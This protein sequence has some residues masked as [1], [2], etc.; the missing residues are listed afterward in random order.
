MLVIVLNYSFA[1]TYNTDLVDYVIKNK[2]ISNLFNIGI[3]IVA[4]YYLFNR[5]FYLPFL[6]P[7]VIPIIQSSQEIKKEDLINV[8]LSNLPPNTNVI[9]WASLKSEKD[10]E[11]PIVAYQDYSNSGIE[12]TDATGNVNIKVVCPSPY[13]VPKFGIKKQLLQRHVHYRYELPN[14][15]GVYSRVYTQYIDSC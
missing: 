14:Y 7:A 11:N 5:D 13:Y 10:F 4:L 8:K 2:T 3:A 15:K 1:K 6:G 12:K 9:Y